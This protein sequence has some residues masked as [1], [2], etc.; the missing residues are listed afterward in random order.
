M[1]RKRRRKEK[2][3]E[4]REMERKRDLV[5]G[6]RGG[7]Q[8]E[9]GGNGDRKKGGGVNEMIAELIKRIK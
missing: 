7:I 2:R 5:R 1:D 3:E 8:K 4:K 6:G 9:N